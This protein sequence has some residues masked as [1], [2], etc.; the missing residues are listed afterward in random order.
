M[1]LKAA[2]VQLPSSQIDDTERIDHRPGFPNVLRRS[3]RILGAHCGRA[4]SQSP[5]ALAGPPETM[6]CSR[7]GPSTRRSAQIYDD[8]AGLQGVVATDVPPR[9]RANAED[10]DVFKT[11]RIIV[12]EMPAFGQGQGAGFSPDDSQGAHEPS[13]S[14]LRRP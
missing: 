4:A 13:H 7:S 8:G 6:S 3:T 12:C 2:H 1:D 14:Y 11:I 10:P 5:D 9:M